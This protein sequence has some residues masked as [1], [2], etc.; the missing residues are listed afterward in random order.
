[1]STGDTFMR[2]VIA[3]LARQGPFED[4][5]NKALA[6]PHLL[7][8]DRADYERI[9]D[10]VLRSDPPGPAEL[11][12]AERLRT[13]ALNATSLITAA[14]ADEYGRYVQIRESTAPGGDG[15]QRE[16]QAGRLAV[17]AVLAPIL[18]GTASA[19]FL[20]VGYI[21]KFLRGNSD[22][23]RAMISEG[24]IFGA[25]TAVCVLLAMIGL[26]VTALRHNPSGGDPDG[27]GPWEADLG[28]EVVAARAAWLTAL[29]V[30]GVQ[31]FLQEVRSAVPPGEPGD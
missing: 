21:T 11:F 30:R 16:T 31:P 10:E 24:W 26:L 2:Q 3:S 28:T 18:A 1:M 27:A 8:R 14:A 4:A 9:I 15:S 22:F 12:T 20:L 13:M 5:G 25:L 29:R 23:A 17:V 7:A 19:C 6:P